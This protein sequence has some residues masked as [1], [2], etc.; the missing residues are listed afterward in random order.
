LEIGSW[1]GA[2]AVT[3]ARAIETHNGGKG[4]VICVDP[5]S[6]LRTYRDTGAP[7]QDMM[8]LVHENEIAW[9]L[10]HHNIEA[11]GLGRLVHAF[12][13]TSEKVLPDLPHGSFDIVFVDGDHLCDAVMVDVGL[14]APLVKEGGFLCGDDLELQAH[15]VSRTEMYAAVEQRVELIRDTATGTI[16]HPG[17][18]LALDKMA[19]PVNEIDGF[20]YACR[21]AS[22]WSNPDIA[23]RCPIPDHVMQWSARA[24]I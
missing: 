11:G 22:G 7:Y 19:L 16:Y 14:A 23:S 1:I 9:R 3:W 13:G 12:R 4:Q 8:N 2:S 17:V 21:E 5:W 24:A 10:F 15:E 18:A 6:D 20:W